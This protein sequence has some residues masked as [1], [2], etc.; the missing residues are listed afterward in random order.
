MDPEAPEPQINP[1]GKRLGQLLID[2]GYLCDEDLARVLR[3]QHESK[4]KRKP[5][6]MICV[7][8]GFLSQERLDLILDRC[9][10]RLGLSELLMSRGRVDPADIER[11][12][13]L[14]RTKGGRLGETLIGMGCIDEVTLTET[15]AEQFDLPYVPL[16]GLDPQPGFARYVNAI[17]SGKHGVV[18]IGILGRCL[19]VAIHDPTQRGLA[20]DLESSTGLRVRIVLSTKSDVQA[21][22]DRL[23]GAASSKPAG[24]GVPLTHEGAAPAELTP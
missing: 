21:H 15:L 4:G 5:I 19:T 16:A 7:E 9:S 3:A 11:A 8:M 17:Y 23:Y 24:A 13:E 12:R 1:Q 10:K 2:L 6:G 22:A 20:F 18:P 14:Q